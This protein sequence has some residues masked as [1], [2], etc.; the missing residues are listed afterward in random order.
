VVV[1]I[2]YSSLL[3]PNS[4]GEVEWRMEVRMEGEAEQHGTKRHASDNLETDQRLSKRLSLLKIGTRCLLSY[5]CSRLTL[6]GKNGQ[7]HVPIKA[8]RRPK[9]PRPQ[10]DSMHIDDTKDKVYIY[11][12]DAELSDTDSEKDQIVFLPE[13]EKRITKIPKSVLLN[14]EDTPPSHEVVLYN[15]PSSLLVPEEKDSVRKAIIESRAR[16][17]EQQ[18]RG[19]YIPPTSTADSGI[20]L[21]GGSANGDESQVQED[22]DSMDID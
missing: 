4:G 18:A 8:P 3:A 9:L 6:V 5:D 12:L 14:R 17:R 20:R 11:D 2:L 16:V 21:G 7:V 1:G 10:N 19:E 13:I 22:S 15:V